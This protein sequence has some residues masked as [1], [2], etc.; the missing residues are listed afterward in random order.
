ML[1]SLAQ[2]FP[3][4]HR[5]NTESLFH[6]STIIVAVWCNNVKRRTGSDCTE[7][8]LAAVQEHVHAQETEKGQLAH[9]SLVSSKFLQI[10][11]PSNE[12]TN[13]HERTCNTNVNALK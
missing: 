6:S 12:N 11:K 2:T 3:A 7:E 8:Q 10:S 5:E 4:E 1:C 13:L 9:V